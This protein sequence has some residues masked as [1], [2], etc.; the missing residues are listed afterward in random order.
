MKEQYMKHHRLLG[1]LAL[2]LLAM[3]NAPATVLYVDLN[4]SNPT[5]TFTNW[6]SAAVTIQDAVDAVVAGDQ[7]L[8]TNGVYKI[9][10][11]PMNGPSK[12]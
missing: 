7:I 5:P 12:S 10:G 9:G 11:E 1:L 6:S 8:V 2:C 3:A 4:S